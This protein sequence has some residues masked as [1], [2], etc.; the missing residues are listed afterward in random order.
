M[1]IEPEQIVIDLSTPLSMRSSF[2][3]P[4]QSETSRREMLWGAVLLVALPGIGW[5]LN[6]GHRVIVS[7][8]CSMINRPGRLGTITESFFDT[9]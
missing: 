4:L 2:R 6:L 5:F 9:A 7:T 1:I 3:F 8:G